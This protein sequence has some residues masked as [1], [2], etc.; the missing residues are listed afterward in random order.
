MHEKQTLHEG[1]WVRLV[2]QGQ[3]E[4]CERTNVS[5][6][7]GIIA[8]TADD[9]IILNQQ[10]RPPVNC[11]M[12]EL[13]AGLVGDEAGREDEPLRE[14][15]RRELEEETGY[16]A[17]SM[18]RVAVG[19]PSAGICDEIITFYLA[20]DLDKVSDGGGDDHE[21]ITVHRVPLA[22]IEDWLNAKSDEGLLIDLKVYLA[23]YFAC[24]HVA[25]KSRS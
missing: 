11:D 15:A 20:T 14:G 24:Q 1:K 21:D 3:W 6:I 25:N 13:P 4:F 7:V 17:G 23:L 8:V 22:G 2:K 10:F 16:H 19:A 9:H 12:I 18:K 5:G